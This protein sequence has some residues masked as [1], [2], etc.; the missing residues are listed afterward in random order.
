MIG[1]GNTITK[2]FTATKQEPRDIGSIDL[3]LP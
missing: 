2:I 1:C 3:D